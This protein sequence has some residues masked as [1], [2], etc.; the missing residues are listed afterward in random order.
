[1]MKN[2]FNIKNIMKMVTK[3]DLEDMMKGITGGGIEK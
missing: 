3:K 2:R 1:M